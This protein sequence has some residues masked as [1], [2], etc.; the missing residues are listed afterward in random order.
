MPSGTSWWHYSKA[1]S[2]QKVTHKLVMTRRRESSSHHQKGVESPVTK[3]A[4]RDLTSVCHTKFMCW[5]NYIKVQSKGKLWIFVYKTVFLLTKGDSRLQKEN[6]I[7]KMSVFVLQ[8]GLSDYN[9]PVIFISNLLTIQIY[10][11][12]VQ[13]RV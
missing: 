6:L 2:S 5:T 10:N 7:Y 8:T 13:N 12:I 9:S 1:C 3:H 11:I 4:E